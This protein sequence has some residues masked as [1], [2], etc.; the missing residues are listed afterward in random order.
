M[1]A[2]EDP[3]LGAE[4]ESPHFAVDAAGEASPL[5]AEAEGEPPAIT[6]ADAEGEA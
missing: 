4:G 5:N 6:E 3:A 1:L 2:T